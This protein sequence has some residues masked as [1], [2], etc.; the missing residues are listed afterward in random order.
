[1]NSEKCRI[2][3]TSLPNVLHQHTMHPDYVT[4]WCG[5]TAEFI[6][7][8]FSL[9]LSLHK[10]IK[11]VLSRVHRAV[12]PFNRRSF[13]LYRNDNVCKPLSLCKSEQHIGCQV[14]S[15]LSANFDKK[16]ISRHFLDAWPFRSL[17][18]NPCDF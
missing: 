9:K 2:W 18:L 4:A 13:L 5:F 10:A 15:L 1:M 3:G 17:D 11:D 12:N 14:K 7:G 16:V 6:L 8:P